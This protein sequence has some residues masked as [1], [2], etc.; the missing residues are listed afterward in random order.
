MPGKTGESRRKLHRSCVRRPLGGK[1]R[2]R[3]AMCAH[4]KPLPCVCAVGDT[5]L[6]PAAFGRLSRTESARGARQ[7]PARRQGTAETS[8]VRTR[9]TVALRV[10]RRG[11]LPCSCGFWAAFENRKLHRSCIRRRSIKCITQKTPKPLWFR[12]FFKN[13]IRTYPMCCSRIFRSAFAAA[14]SGIPFS[15]MRTALLFGQ[16]ASS[17]KRTGVCF[18]AALPI[19]R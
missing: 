8:D 17:S 1:A 5:F 4:G 3:Q 6:A 19:S 15:S 16:M 10:R 12:R 2:Q 18:M 7:A 9:K 11:H 14:A 13:G